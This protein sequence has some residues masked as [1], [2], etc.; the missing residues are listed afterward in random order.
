MKSHLSIGFFC[1]GSKIDQNWSFRPP[2]DPLWGVPGGGSQGTFWRFC[3]KIQISMRISTRICVFRPKPHEFDEKRKK[4]EFWPK[5]STKRYELL[6]SDQ[7]RP[8][9]TKIWPILVTFR[10]PGTPSDPYPPIRTKKT[11]NFRLLYKNEAYIQKSGVFL[12]FFPHI[13]PK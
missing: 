12:T 2:Q 1:G 13:G 11:R 7:I 5:F 9:R 10:P 6:D 3:Q 8:K 4:S